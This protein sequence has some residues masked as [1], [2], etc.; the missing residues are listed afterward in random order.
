MAPEDQEISFRNPVPSLK[1]FISNKEKVQ[2]HLA[3]FPEHHR[4]HLQR[5]IND[6]PILNLE[7]KI[8]VGKQQVQ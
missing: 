3:L 7:V 1:D 8:M 4:D 6:L 5:Q 2:Q